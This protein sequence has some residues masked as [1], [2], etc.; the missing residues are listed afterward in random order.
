MLDKSTLSKPLIDNVTLK[1][2]EIEK[3]DRLAREWW[4]ENGKMKSALKFNRARLA[5][6]K[7][8]ISQHFSLSCNN[9]EP[10]TGLSIL[11]VGSGGGLLSEPL[12]QY[13]AQVLGIDASAVSI[14]VARRHAEH[15]RTK[16]LKYEH[17]L[18]KEILQR[19]Q[20]FDVVINAEVVEHVAEQQTLIDECCGLVKPGGMLVLATLNKT[21]KSYIVAILGAE[22]IMRYLPIGTHDWRY[23]VKP[24]T[25]TDWTQGNGFSAFLQTGMA[26]N[27]ITGKWRYTK[28]ISVNYCICFS[29]D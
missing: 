6:I 26:L 11:D 21:L 4:D 16:N 23:F 3:F 19:G 2:E 1:P 9:E 13:G 10:L 27:P 25:L 8:A 14:E 15:T 20:R 12:A 7:N 28:D 29:K 18:S 17:V 5:Y 22:Y 24:D